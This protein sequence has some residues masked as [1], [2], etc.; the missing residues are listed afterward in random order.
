MKL[1]LAS[2]LL[3]VFL[4]PSIALGEM[5][6]NPQIEFVA[7]CTN[8]HVKINR[9]DGSTDDGKVENDSYDVSLKG[10]VLTTKWPG[11]TETRWVYQRGLKIG[12]PRDREIYLFFTPEEEELSVTQSASIVMEE[13]NETKIWYVQT[14]PGINSGKAFARVSFYECAIQF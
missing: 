5:E 12:E 1:F 2:T 3:V 14:Q 7:I 8:T 10:G 13:R 11:L 9:S 4:F 6:A